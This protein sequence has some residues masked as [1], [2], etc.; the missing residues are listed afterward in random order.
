MTPNMSRKDRLSAFGEQAGFTVRVGSDL[1]VAEGVPCLFANGKVGSCSI[2]KSFDPGTGKPNT[3]IGDHVHVVLIKADE[4]HDGRV[5][6]ADGNP[7]GN[8]IGGDGKTWSKISIKKG[9]PGSPRA[10]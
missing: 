10:I 1:V 7:I 4:E 3:R 6:Q 9:S 8:Y 5:Y 2:E